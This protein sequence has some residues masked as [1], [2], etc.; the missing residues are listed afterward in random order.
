[1]VPYVHSNL[2]TTIFF[3]FAI[4][5]S[6]L[7]TMARSAAVSPAIEMALQSVLE[8]ADA[9]VQPRLFNI[10]LLQTRQFRPLFDASEII[11]PHCFPRSRLKLLKFKFFFFFLFLLV[12]KW[13]RLFQTLKVCVRGALRPECYNFVHKL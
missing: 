13:G 9:K 11:Y 10:V 12:Q 4:D 6:T 2:N 5:V 1:M 7:M 3:H 8:S